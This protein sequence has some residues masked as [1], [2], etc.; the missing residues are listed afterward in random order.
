[1]KILYFDCFSGISGDMTIGALVDLGVPKDYLLSELNKLSISNEYEIEIK[2][3]SKCGIS[4]T[5]F[6]VI[7]KHHHHHDHHDHDHHGR[8]L[9]DIEKIID[10]STLNDNVKRT[11]KYIFNIIAKAE[12]EV[13]GKDIDEVHFHEVGAVDSIVDIVGTAICIDYIKPDKVLSSP[14]NTGRGFVECEHGIIPVPAPATL[15]I[16]KNIPIYSDER[17]FE[18]TTP[19]G[20]AILKGLT[21]EF[22][23]LPELKVIKEG[24]GLGK[25]DTKKPNLLR[26]ILAEKDIEDVCILEATI[27]DMNPQLYGHLMDKLF[28]AG[29]RDVYYT[30]VYMK[31]NRPGIVVTITTPASI[32]DK[33]Q[34]IMFK[35]TTTIGIRKYSIDRTELSREIKTLDTKYGSIRFKVS[36]YKGEIVNISPEYEDLKSVSEKYNVPLKKVAYDVAQFASEKLK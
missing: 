14:V 18:L 35:E 15:K 26:I 22:V 36:S 16:L 7:L 27:D 5:D 2:K 23:K 3:G 31:K 21:H 30:P 24:Y 34:E 9:K 12:S 10:E 6:K 20:A 29:V 8:N 1:M 17:E 13:H 28:E 19:T 25:R 4:G 11:S 33:I 32:K